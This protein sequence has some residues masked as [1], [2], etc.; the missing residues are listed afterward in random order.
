MT[1]R[2]FTEATIT[3]AVLERVAAAPDGRVRQVSQALVKHL[4]AF[5]REIEPTEAEWEWGIRFLTTAGQVCSDT[6]QE[7]ILLSD[8]LGVSM[9]V[10]AI[11]H[12]L[13]LG[14]TETTVFGP[15]YVSPAEFPLGADIRGHLQ[16]HPMHVAGRV[17]DAEGHPLAGA[18][19]DVWHSDAD[20]FY[21]L[22]KLDERH[23]YAG[24]G[25]FQTDKDGRFHFWTIRPSPYPIPDDGPVGAML[26]AQ[27]RHPFRPEHIHFMIVAPGHRKLVTHIFAAGDKYLDSDAVFGVKTSLVEEYRVHH[28]GK[29]PDGRVIDGDWF[30]LDR[31]FRLASGT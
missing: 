23:R 6:R 11:N 13:P 25:R 1:I 19:V 7:F 18:T 14:A 22:Q 4:H 15:F 24:R 21:D 29:A 10:D 16:G 3:D 27:G 31:E 8:T 12:R 2:E 5:I 28:G 17:T 30:S 20:G 9:L 26:R